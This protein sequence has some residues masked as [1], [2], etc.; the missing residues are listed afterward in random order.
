MR[1]L[2]GRVALVT[3]AGAGIG[4]AV[5]ERLADEGVTVAVVDRDGARLIGRSREQDAYTA[6]AGR[7]QTREG[8]RYRRLSRKRG[9]AKALVAVGNTQVRVYHVLLSSP[10]TRYQDLGWDYYERERN[11]AR[12]VSHHVG[13]LGSL[14][15]EVTLA[16]RPEPDATRDMQAA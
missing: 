3:G 16:R 1:G 8:A 11:I 5:A 10:G 6:A 2:S 13:K 12:Q 9:K 4:A 7:T 14:G 15:Y